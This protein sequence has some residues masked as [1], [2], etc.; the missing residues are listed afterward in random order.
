MTIQVIC[1]GTCKN[2]PE[3]INR[4]ALLCD[5]C[6]WIDVENEYKRSYVNWEDALPCCK[7]EKVK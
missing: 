5:T 6:I 1:C 4:N 7:N 2:H 3:N